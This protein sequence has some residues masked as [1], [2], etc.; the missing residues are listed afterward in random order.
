MLSTSGTVGRIPAYQ[1][2][3]IDGQVRL[4]LLVRLQT[5]TFPLF[6]RNKLTNEKL[7]LHDEQTVNGLRKI[8]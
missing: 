4:V 2:I 3:N 5:D 6:L 7:P 1:V 8:T